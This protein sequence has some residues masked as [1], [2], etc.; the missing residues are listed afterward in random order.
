MSSQ[1]EID[2]S[3]AEVLWLLNDASAHVST[4]ILT[5][6]RQPKKKCTKKIA[7]VEIAP[8]N[9]HNALSTPRLYLRICKKKRAS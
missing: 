5:R 9:K 8:Q 2:A 4:A 7:L 1:C 3:Q 6:V